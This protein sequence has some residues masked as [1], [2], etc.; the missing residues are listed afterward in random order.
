M[1]SVSLSCALVRRAPFLDSGGLSTQLG[2]RWAELDLCLR[3]GQSG[4]AIHYQPASEFQHLVTGNYPDH[5]GAAELFWDRWSATVQPDDVGYYVQDELLSF[6]HWPTY[7][8]QLTVSPLLAETEDADRQL[9][10]AQLLQ[11]YAR[12]VFELTVEHA[13][14]RNS[15]GA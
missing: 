1:R 13:R 4:Y 6:D 14:L 15:P 9:A 2:W 10:A 5:P 11:A 12:S 3:L 8:A 7:P